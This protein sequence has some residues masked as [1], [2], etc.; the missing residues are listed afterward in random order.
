MGS[1]TSL[2]K[3]K[4]AEPGYV[5]PTAHPFY[6]RDPTIEGYTNYGFNSRRKHLQRFCRPIG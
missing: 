3:K 4:N 2:E 1:V 5:L 6:V